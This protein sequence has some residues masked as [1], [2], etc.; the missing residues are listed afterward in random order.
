MDRELLRKAL[1]LQICRQCFGAFVQHVQPGYLM[2]WVHERICAEL[3][4]FL[5]DVVDGKSPG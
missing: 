1:R 3:D 2:G 5:Q 4:R